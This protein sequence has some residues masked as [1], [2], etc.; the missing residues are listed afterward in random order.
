LAP[1]ARALLLGNEVE[2]GAE[3]RAC[4]T[5]RVAKQCMADRFERHAV[6]Q[7]NRANDCGV[8]SSRVAMRADLGVRNENF[9]EPAV[10]KARNGCD[11]DQ[12]VALEREGL[13][14][15]AVR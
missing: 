14:R 6:L 13:A 12:A 15:A 3:G 5:L 7:A 2:R 8:L 4:S 11:I 9:R 10:L 1:I